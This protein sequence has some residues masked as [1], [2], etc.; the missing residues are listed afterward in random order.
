MLGCW[1]LFPL[2]L[3]L[4]A[5]GCGLLLE[6]VAAT[7]LPGAVVPAAGLAVVVVA[8]HFTTLSDATAELSVPVV[9]ALAVAGFA[10]SFPWK[11]G[12]IDWWAMVAGG[13]VFAIYAA[14]IVL[15]G[16]TTFTGYIK[17]DDTATWLALADRIMEHGRDL[18]GLPGS[19]YEATLAFNL[20]GGYPIGAFLPLGIGRALAGQDGAWVFQPYMAFLAAMLAETFYVLVAPVVRSR[21]LRALAAFVASQAALLFGYYL[22]GGV[23]EV[24]AAWTLG[25]IA[26]VAL[27]ATIPDGAA[28]SVLP[29]AVAGAATLAVLSF[30]GTVWVGPL[31]LAAL[32]VT[33]RTRG[34]PFAARRAI[35]FLLAGVVLAVP[36]LL[37]AEQFLSPS[38]GT[39][40]SGTDLGNLIKPLDWIQFFGI[41]PTGDFR[42]EPE[43][44]TATHLLIAVVAAAALLG[45]VTAWRRRADGLLIYTC[46]ATVG[47]FLVVMLGSPWVDAKALAT[48]SPAF[49]LAGIAAGSAVLESGRRIE[50][51]LIVA[52]ITGGVLWSNALAYQDVTL[53]PR[54][55]LGELQYI[56]ERYAGQGPALMTEYEPY[57]VRHF[58]RRLDPEGAS[59]L[60]RRLVPLRSGRS[61]DKLEVA[62][63][64]Q[65]QLSGL[66]VYRTLV[67]RTSPVQSRPP[68]PFRLVRR[69]RYYDVWQR[70]DAPSGVVEH[71][72]LGDALHATAPAR[73]RDVLRLA[74]EAGPG[75][76]LAAAVRGPEPIVVDLPSATRPS[77]WQPV[78]TATGAVSPATAGSVQTL[79]HVPSAARYGIWVG[80]AFRREL[81]VRV[82]GEEVSTH[83]HELSHSGQYA[84]LG[85]ALLTA[86]VHR[87]ALHYGEADLHPGSGDPPFYLG[88]LVLARPEDVS[89]R[90][91]S[92]PDARSLCGEPLDWIEALR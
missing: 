4:L 36:S 27:P 62:D 48:A 77:A 52:V 33:L 38:R 30:G 72:P 21:A 74:R 5:L 88:P 87:V 11:R 26:A 80:G 57:G 25:L 31:L 78:P 67:L 49:V 14:P 64:D 59:E 13:G 37:Q 28:R 65:F 68:S 71:L 41:W 17:L 42:V 45:L 44:I 18:S 16:E 10:L 12:S 56:G 60:R 73:C 29:L 89:V 47:C 15:S 76:R 19:S 7:R 69:G 43:S 85:Q 84:P 54:D 66:M 86:G 6:V 8:T 40:T 79:V 24:A 53:A 70:A 32:L 23:K 34:A 55:R 20:P 81:I 61:L 75:G 1:V 3:T 83:R 58:L 2:V 46:G 39:L 63:I 92:G 82:D 90:Y 91:V 51:L 9:V 22:W 35:A 50:G